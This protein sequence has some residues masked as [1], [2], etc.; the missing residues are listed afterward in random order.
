MRSSLA[1]IHYRVLVLFPVRQK[2]V[3][4]SVEEPVAPTFV[5]PGRYPDYFLESEDFLSAKSSR[6]MDYDMESKVLSQQRKPAIVPALVLDGATGTPA[7]PGV[8]ATASQERG[9]QTINQYY[10]D[11]SGVGC[12]HRTIPDSS[13]KISTRSTNPLPSSECR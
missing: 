2:K 4:V 5:A 3:K 1:C 10:V 12:R 6:T 11:A 9:T 8:S 7:K 13:G